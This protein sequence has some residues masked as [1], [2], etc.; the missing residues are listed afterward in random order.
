MSSATVTGGRIGRPG[1]TL[2]R[3]APYARLDIGLAL[4]A[5]AAFI[6]LNVL[7]AGPFDFSNVEV[8]AFV[9]GAWSVWLVVKNDVWNWPIGIANGGIFVWLFFDAKLYADAGIN[10]FYVVAGAYGWWFWMRGG[11]QRSQ[12]PISRAAL[13]EW[14]VIAVAVGLGTW[15][16][17]GHL[18]SLGDSAPLLD[19]LTT[20]ASI[21][22]FWMQARRY[23]DQWILWIAVDLI[24]IPLYFWKSL[25]L[26]GALY[27]LFLGMCLVGARDWR[28]QLAQAGR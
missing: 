22:A 17:Y 25:P 20:A 27:V 28:R 7:R 14:L 6:V 9:T 11:T 3:L 5:S 13:R 16:M 10:A 15:W 19:G 24:Y 4:V 21:A 2:R 8:A 26:T 23:I 18:V 12:R 1:R